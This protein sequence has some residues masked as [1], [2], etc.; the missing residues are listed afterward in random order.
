MSFFPCLRPDPEFS[1][2]EKMSECDLLAEAAVYLAV[3]RVNEDPTILPNVKLKI[4]P[5]YIPN[6]KDLFTVSY[7]YSHSIK[8]FTCILTD[9]YAHGSGE[10]MF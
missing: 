1:A 6:D 3:D 10:T 5:V 8:L 4:H 7:T 9:I 2:S